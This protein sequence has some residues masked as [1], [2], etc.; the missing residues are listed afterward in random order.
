[1]FRNLRQKLKRRVAPQKKRTDAVRVR[2][3]LE[4]LE[5]RAMLSASYGSMGHGHGG[6][7]LAPRGG[8]SPHLGDSATVASPQQRSVSYDT[9]TFSNGR[10]V[11]GSYRELQSGPTMQSAFQSP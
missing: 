2:G 1:M 5:E 8:S 4:R 6:S 7:Q 9:Q 10:Q 3:A 11:D